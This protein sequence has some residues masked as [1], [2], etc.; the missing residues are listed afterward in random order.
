MKI[1]RFL[2]KVKPPCPKCPYELGLIKTLCC[3]CPGCKLNGYRMAE[4]FSKMSVKCGW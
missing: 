4:R 2:Y 1:K 3:P